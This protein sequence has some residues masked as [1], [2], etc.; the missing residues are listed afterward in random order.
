[1]SDNDKC[2]TDHKQSVFSWIDLAVILLI[3]FI[4]VIVLVAVF[5]RYVLNHSLSWSDEVVRYLFVWF[6]L[7]GSA[8]VFRDRRHIRIEYFVELFPKKLKRFCE[9]AGFFLIVL[10]HIFLFFSGIA[11][12][13]STHG[14]FT[15]SLKMPLNLI[16][17]AA[18]PVSAAMTLFFSWKRFQ[19]GSYTE[20]ESGT[21]K[22]DAKEAEN[23]ID[24]PS[25]PEDRN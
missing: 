19:E 12:T 1:M 7:I 2:T 3:S 22:I 23:R 15:S 5:F 6:I 8:L 17:Y 4:L 13:I 21:V 20:L 10:F 11:W 16:F 18:I 9:I 14:S 25:S 24:I